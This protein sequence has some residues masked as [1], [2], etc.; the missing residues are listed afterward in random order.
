MKKRQESREKLRASAYQSIMAIEVT[1]GEFLAMIKKLQKGE[2]LSAEDRQEIQNAIYWRKKSNE[3]IKK[4]D[5]AA[6]GDW[7]DAHAG[8]W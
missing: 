7:A 5:C 4:L 1:V 8:K 2:V 3:L 6:G